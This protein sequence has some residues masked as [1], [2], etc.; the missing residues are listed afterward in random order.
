MIVIKVNNEAYKLL[1]FVEFG[2]TLF[3][4]FHTVGGLLKNI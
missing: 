4:F 3:F 2:E 1:F